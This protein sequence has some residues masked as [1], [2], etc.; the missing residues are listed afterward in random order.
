M[1][2][3]RQV[4]DLYEAVRSISDPD[5]FQR[6]ING[7]TDDYV[8]ADL[9]K[10]FWDG[11]GEKPWQVIEINR[12]LTR[13]K[14]AR[15]TGSSDQGKDA[16]PGRSPSLKERIENKL[17]VFFLGSLLTGFVAGLA[18]YQG[19]LKLVDYTAVSN[20]ALRTLKDDIEKK[21]KEITTLGARVKAAEVNVGEQRWLRIRGVEG[22]DGRRA[23]LVA[24]VNGRAYSYPSRAV[25]SHLGP[26][27]PVEDFPLPV[28]VKV[29]DIS[30]E[31]LTLAPDNQFRQFQSQEVISVKSWPFEAEYKI[32]AVTVEQ[33]GTVRDSTAPIGIGSVR[34]VPVRERE[35]IAR[36]AFEVR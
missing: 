11:T 1:N 25:W 9:R 14:E 7:E 20:D 22:L 34:G 24:R 8:L 35:A 26:G 18:V 13:R 6:I 21:G 19:A 28:D 32:F 12:L 36:V 33:A 15:L 3:E 27:M 5:A 29:Y 23:R 4:A 2:R 30:F 10:R 31:L 16:Q 17:V